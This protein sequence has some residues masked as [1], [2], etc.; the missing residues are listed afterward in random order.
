MKKIYNISGLAL[1]STLLI[2]CVTSNAP[3]AY[4]DL[5]YSPNNDP[6]QQAQKNTR[7]D[8]NRSNNVQYQGGYDNRYSNTEDAADNRQGV[9]QNRYTEE[10]QRENTQIDSI[11]TEAIEQEYSDEYYDEGYAQTLQQINSPVR[12]FNTYDPYQRDRI[13]YTQD[14]LF[15]TPSVYGAYQFSNPFVPTTGLS[16]GRNSFSGWNVGVNIGYAGGVWMC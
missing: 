1:I 4:D 11:Q 6:V 7:D 14:P 8:L 15:V 10:E 16:V 5:Y 2:G 12:S 9:Y 3:Y 13:L